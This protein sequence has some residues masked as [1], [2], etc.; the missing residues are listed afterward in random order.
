MP[1][2][3][4]LAI[5]CAAGLRSEF[6]DELR[7]L[8]RNIPVSLEPIMHIAR[9]IPYGR[10]HKFTALQSLKINMFKLSVNDISCLLRL[11]SLRTLHLHLVIDHINKGAH[12]FNS[13]KS[14]ESTWECP[15]GSSK[16]DTLRISGQEIRLKTLKSLV[17]ACYSLK[18]LQFPLPQFAPIDEIFSMLE[19]HRT[20]LE[21]L[22]ICMED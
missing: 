15:P 17:L 5:N 6:T 7:Y 19:Y 21:N 16:I 12:S 11:P 14:Q 9:G 2:L 1:N 22:C 13:G 10:V 18:T 8:M 3:V 4:S 20:T